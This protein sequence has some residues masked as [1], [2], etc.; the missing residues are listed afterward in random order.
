MIA[1]CPT[2]GSRRFR[3]QTA[4]TLRDKLAEFLGT[5]R[6]RCLEC[7]ASY[8]KKWSVRDWLYA[9]CP[10]CYRQDLGFWTPEFYNAPLGVAMKLSMGAKRYRCE[11]SR[12]N[13]A[14]FR[15]LRARYK[16]PSERS[17]NLMKE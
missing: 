10:R 7:G 12:H 5:F 8:Q 16:R 17:G 3:V 6:L 9:K 15:F 2:C 14:S 13:F 1:F 4:R 11:A